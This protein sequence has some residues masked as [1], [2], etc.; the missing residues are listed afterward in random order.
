MRVCCSSSFS[1]TT[2]RCCRIPAWIEAVSSSGLHGLVRKRKTWPW[3]TA[4][5]AVFWSELPVS[6]IRVV[7]GASLATSFSTSRPLRP[8]MRMSAT[9]TANGP[10]C[11]TAWS[12]WRPPMATSSSKNRRRL[13][14]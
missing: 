3:F 4:S 12:A 13:R 11:S 8:G 10:W 5:T 9:I 6:M 7:S 2:R 14:W 1:A